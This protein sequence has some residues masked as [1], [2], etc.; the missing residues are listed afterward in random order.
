[1]NKHLIFLT[2]IIIMISSCS[3]K[4]STSIYK[5]YAVLDYRET[6]LIFGLEDPEPADAEQIGV[7]KIGDT[8]FTADCSLETVLERAKAEAR[9]IGGNGL[10][11]TKH[12]PPSMW[13]SS[14]HR[15]TATILK[16]DNTENYT[17]PATAFDDSEDADYAILYVYRPGG[18]GGLINYDL[19]LG[20]SV[21]CRVLNN[22]KDTIIINKDGLNTLWARTEAKFELPINIRF[23]NE[24]YI[25]CL[26]GGG[27]FV[28]RPVLEIVD[29]QIGR[30]EFQS[31]AQNK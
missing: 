31:V 10:K 13:G 22:W 30:F 2:G 21:I 26:I 25:R 20:D 12:D 27:M 14:C 5:Q 1:M 28:G 18:P 23:G 3:P 4:I 19:H 9:K 29:N 11:I 15:I 6:V 7:V 16:I 17:L 24:Y 8:G